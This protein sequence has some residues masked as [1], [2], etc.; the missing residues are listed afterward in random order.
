MLRPNADVGALLANEPDQAV[1]RG[2]IRV[3]IVA[4]LT[5]LGGRDALTLEATKR[6][7]ARDVSARLT[8]LSAP[9]ALTILAD[10]S[11]VAERSANARRL[12]L[13]QIAARTAATIRITLAKP[14]SAL[15]AFC[16]R[17]SARSLARHAA[18]DG[19]IAQQSL[20]RSRSRLGAARD[21]VGRRSA[22]RRHQMG[23]T[24]R[25]QCMGAC[26]EIGIRR[27]QHRRS[28]RLL[29]VAELLCEAEAR[30]L[31]RCAHGGRSSG[32]RH[33]VS[34]F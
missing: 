13:R 34:A 17:A 27:L 25:S 29:L 16:A 2:C 22:P 21:A 24:A 32:A 20:A 30:V 18:G 12:K 28:A 33:R 19:R 4:A 11:P 8:Q 31:R 26:G 5:R 6:A 3:G 10:Q 14:A 9:L 23:F 7:V 15:S 1:A